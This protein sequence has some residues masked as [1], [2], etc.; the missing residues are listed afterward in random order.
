MSRLT[1]VAGNKVNR[2]LQEVLEAFHLDLKQAPGFLRVLAGSSAVTEAYMAAEEALAKGQL[3]AGQREQIALAVAEINNSRYC[4]IAHTV[5]GR[6]AG[7]NN[8]DIHLARKATANDP[9]AE[10]MLRFTQAVALQRGEISDEGFKRLQS[11]GFSDAEVIEII[12]NIALNIFANYLSSV[13]RTE[14]DF[15]LLHPALTNPKPG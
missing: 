11:A 1:P 2:Q 10:A 12:A 15:P 13:S 3:T 8:E 9:K 6:A 4:L 5:T 14:V 7:L